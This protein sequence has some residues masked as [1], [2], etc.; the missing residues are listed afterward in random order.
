VYGVCNIPPPECSVDAD[1]D[2]D[3]A[4]TQDACVQGECVHTPIPGPTCTTLRVKAGWIFQGTVGFPTTGGWPAGEWVSCPDFPG[5]DPETDV[6][7]RTLTVCEGET[8]LFNVQSVPAQARAWAIQGTWNGANWCGSP[9]VDSSMFVGTT[10]AGAGC[11][12][13]CTAEGY[14][15]WLCQF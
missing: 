2:D 5:A 10:P 15:N 3:N 1:C 9:D 8:A 14:L 12:V 6:R 13:V 4:G 11:S 7:C